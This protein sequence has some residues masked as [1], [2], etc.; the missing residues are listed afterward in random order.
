MRAAGRIAT[1]VLGVLLGAAARAEAP[2]AHPVEQG[3]ACTDCH[4]HQPAEAPELHPSNVLPKDASVAEEG[5]QICTDCH[6]GEQSHVVGVK[7]DFTVPA[8]LPLDADG[9]ITCLT[10]HYTHGSLQSDTPRA[11]FSFMDR[12]LGDP[13][14]KKSY[15]LRRSNV[16]GELCLACHQTSR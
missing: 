6:A 5:V 15:L 16:H 13:G 11:S 8:D 1:L 3:K 10:C 9:A 2:V 14:L 4:V 7:L 12:L